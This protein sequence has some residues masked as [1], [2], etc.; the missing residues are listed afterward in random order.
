[1]GAS[2]EGRTAV[3]T[4]SSSGI[5][6]AIAVR[7]G[8]EGAF[9]ALSGRDEAALKEAAARI[10]A[11]GGRTH[12]AVGDVREEG[13]V[14]GL[15]DAAVAATGRLDVM[16]NNAGIS[17]L[18]PVLEGDAARWQEMFDVN[19]VALLVGCQAAVR[20]MRETATPGH[21][22]NISSVAAQDPAS[23][24]YG[25]TKHAVNVISKTLRLELLEEPIKVTTILPGVI[26]TNLAR[27]LS[28]EVLSSI[29]ALSGLDVEL[30]PG[31]R[32]PDEVLERAQ[33]ALSEFVARPE[34][35]ADAVY[36]AV[37]QPS[38]VHVTE[39]VVRPKR[40]LALT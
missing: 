12:V 5:G 8:A 14:T 33:A 13:H 7:L 2:L 16:V 19:V 23:G 21:I 38:G 22:F 27:T 17:Y 25:A 1:M 15:V 4:G 6:R 40:D 20:A 37:T 26:A 32:V 18:G 9:V 39:V 24:V 11:S 28:P 10:E 34:D 3:V 31:E 36:Y 29:T 30:V 35:V